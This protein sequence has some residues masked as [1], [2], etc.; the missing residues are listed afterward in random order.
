MKITTLIEDRPGRPDLTPEFGLSLFIETDTDRILLDTGKTGAFMDNAK[1]LGKE[2]GQVDL[3]LIS[4]GHFDHGGGLDRFMTTH[5]RVPV[6]LHKWAMGEFYATMGSKLPDWANAI[7]P[8]FIQALPPFRRYIG[9]D[10]EMLS[11]KGDRLHLVNRPWYFR[12][13][14]LFITHVPRIHP[15]PLGNRS[16]LVRDQGK[17]KPDGFIH[18]IMLVIREDDGLVLF[19]GCCH[20]GILN[21]V[22]ALRSRFPKE[23]IKAVVGGFHLKRQPDEDVQAIGRSLLDH[24][25]PRIITGHCTGNRGQEILASILGDRLEALTT[26]S[27]HTV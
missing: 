11:E 16:L 18:E 9:L 2:L 24:H 23:P 1:A 15:A 8:G 26:G 7:V 19:S 21:M 3:A 17:L 12:E 27:S 25:I 10:R 5:P 13:D 14:I 4:H 6:Y 20:S 22:A